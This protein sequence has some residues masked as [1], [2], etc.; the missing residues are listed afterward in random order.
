[1]LWLPKVVQSLRLGWGLAKV[2]LSAD[3]VVVTQSCAVTEIGLGLAKVCLSADHVVVTQSCAVTETGLG[4]G[5]SLP[6][7]RSCCV[8]PKLCS[9]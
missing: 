3:H 5:Q 1:M 4:A 8:Y 2:C 9:H 7:S 6:V